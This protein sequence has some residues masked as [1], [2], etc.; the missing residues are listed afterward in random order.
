[1]IND[2]IIPIGILKKK[3]LDLNE[4]ENNQKRFCLELNNKEILK[5][6]N[7]CVENLTKIL[8]ESCSNTEEQLTTLQNSPSFISTINNN[9]QKS[10]SITQNIYKNLH[11]KLFKV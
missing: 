10:S 2:H 8:S 11:S 3:K 1:M 9:Q 6:V 5:N 4:E 7:L